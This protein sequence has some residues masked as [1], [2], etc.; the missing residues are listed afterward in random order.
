MAVSGFPSE[1]LAELSIRQLREL[2]S[3]LGVGRY[4]RMLKEQLVMAIETRSEEAPEQTVAAIASVAGAEALSGNLFNPADDASGTDGSGSRQSGATRVH[5]MPRD[6]Q[7]AYVFWQIL[8][9]DERRARESGG[10][11]LTLRLADVTGRSD[12]GAQPHT[13][14][15][16]VVDAGALEWYLPVPVPGRDYRVELGYRRSGGGWISLA[17]SA[18][19]RMPA[20]DDAILAHP[21]A[22]FSLETFGPAGEEPLPIASVGL[23][24][25]VY[26]QAS[27]PRRL[28][29]RGS[30]AFHELD[31]DNQLAAGGQLSGVG[32]W[33]SGRTESGAGISRQRSFWL[34]ADA[35]LIV[36]GATEPDAT[37]RIGDE[38]VPLT[39]EGTFQ[40]QV[41][42]RDGD[43]LYP[44][45]AVA[46]DGDQTRSIALHFN[47]TTP[48]ANVNCRED[49]VAEW[50]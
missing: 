33:A 23:H 39:A 47:R 5:F 42:F 20:T 26:Q 28:V 41:P 13:L 45:S 22:P 27:V 15:E 24:E 10:E 14:Q 48:E 6:P 19:A 3:R 1:S 40:V 31:I 7:W 25:R 49:A 35:E 34:V 2:A 29:S 16:I 43:Q 21:F 17:F 9:A 50:F 44:I 18:P 38:V 36:Y 4:S 32:A 46:A 8:P 12:G 11:Q 37:L 30:E